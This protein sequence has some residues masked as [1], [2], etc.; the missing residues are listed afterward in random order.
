MRQQ[1]WDEVFS[2]EN[3]IS[4]KPEQNLTALPTA[5]ATRRGWL[6]LRGESSMGRTVCEIGAQ[7]NLASNTMSIYR[8]RILEQTGNQNDVALVPY[9]QRHSRSPSLG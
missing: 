9:A 8:A 2:F 6:Q 7:L 3:L 1:P 5:L 4:P